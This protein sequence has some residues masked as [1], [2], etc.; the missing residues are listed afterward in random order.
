M[1]F[2]SFLP[3][4]ASGVSGLAG[5]LSNKGKTST[6]TGTM[7]STTMPFVSDQYKGLEANLLKFLT[8]RMTQKGDL[9]GYETNAL[10]QINRTSGL[11][12]QTLEN[13]LTAMG[14]SDSPVAAQAA[15]T[16]EAGRGGQIATLES[17][18]PL[19]YRQMQDED[20]ANALQLF[21]KTL[22]SKTTGTSTGTGTQ[23]GNMLAGGF[24]SA[25]SML[26]FLYGKGAFDK[27]PAGA[28]L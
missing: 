27:K 17:S 16:M 22:G 5:A 12:A 11:Q 19:I 24:G 10:R 18:L 21:S 2:L 25:A 7:E 3:W 13:R 8:D 26:G 9:G 1:G 15:A 23:P 28:S 4:V 20:Y 14:L 6:Q